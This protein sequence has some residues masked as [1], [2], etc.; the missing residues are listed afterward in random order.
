VQASRNTANPQSK[1]TSS[2]KQSPTRTPVLKPQR[3]SKTP[4]KQIELEEHDNSVD[5]GP[6][7]DLGQRT[8]TPQLIPSQS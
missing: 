4:L 5:E 6:N 3:A 2:F 1:N 8:M 7:R